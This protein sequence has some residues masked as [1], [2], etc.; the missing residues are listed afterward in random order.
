MYYLQ[1]EWKSAVLVVQYSDIK[2]CYDV[3]MLPSDVIIHLAC[4]RVCVCVC[5]C[6]SV[7]THTRNSQ[8]IFP[9]CKDSL[10][11]QITMFAMVVVLLPWF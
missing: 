6:V 10:T 8:F 11:L 1:T 5:V 3:D 9:N 4:V 7:C 2:A